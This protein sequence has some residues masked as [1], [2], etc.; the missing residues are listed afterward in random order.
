MELSTIK[1]LKYINEIM[2]EYNV[3]YGDNDDSTVQ[4]INHRTTTFKY[5]L[6]LDPLKPLATLE[7]TVK[8]PDVV[9]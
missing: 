6:T 1:R 3:K 7:G 9:Q 2:Y 4:K 8:D 5:I